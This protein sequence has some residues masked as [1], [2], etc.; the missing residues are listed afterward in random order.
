MNSQIIKY[1]VQSTSGGSGNT[2][3]TIPNAGQASGKAKTTY[4]MLPDCQKVLSM[5]NVRFFG[6]SRV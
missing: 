3:Y 4:L 2:L 5:P 6:S 1:T